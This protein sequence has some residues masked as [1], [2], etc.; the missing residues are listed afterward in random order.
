T[1]AVIFDAIL[2]KTPKSPVHLNGELPLKLEEIISKALEKDR[3]LRCQTA[4]ELKADLK[5][6][7]R[8]LDSQERTASP[9]SFSTVQN[10][11][12]AL[13]KSVAVLYFENLSGAKEDEYFRDGM[14]EDVITELAKIKTI[15]VFPRAAVLAYRDKPATGPE[16]GQQLN[17]AYVLG[18]SVRRSGNRLRITVQLVE[19]RT[20]HSVWADRY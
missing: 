8:D 4:A 20:G 3:D 13:E 7:K 2:H 18:G 9:K 1:S 15:Q 11:S 12:G 16:V 19:T 5:R 6:L 10:A 14:T 17:A